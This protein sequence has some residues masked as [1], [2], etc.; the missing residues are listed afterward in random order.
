MGDGGETL[1][2]SI[3]SLSH[4]VLNL[5]WHR[6]QWQK[7][8]LAD[9]SCRDS[10]LWQREREKWVNGNIMKLHSECI[11]TSDSINSGVSHHRATHSHALAHIQNISHGNEVQQE[12]LYSVWLNEKKNRIP[13]LG[14][15]LHFCLCTCK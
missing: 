15:G 11:T 14:I 13:F 3:V 5:M 4:N 9:D 6:D 8:T 10:W 12:R 7:K 1:W 2:R